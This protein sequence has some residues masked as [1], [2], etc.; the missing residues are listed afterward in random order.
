[1]ASASVGKDFWTEDRLEFILK[2]SDNCRKQWPG[3]AEKKVCPKKLEN[4]TA[5]FLVMSELM[6][7]EERAI[8][9]VFHPGDTPSDFARFKDSGAPLLK[10]RV[11]TCATRVTGNLAGK[12]DLGVIPFEGMPYAPVLIPDWESDEF[13]HPF[14]FITAGVDGLSRETGLDGHN[15]VLSD[16]ISTLDH[17][18]SLTQSGWKVTNEGLN[19][20]A[21]LDAECSKLVRVPE[22]IWFN[23]FQCLLTFGRTGGEV[24]NDEI[25]SG[26]SYQF[27]P[28]LNWKRWSMEKFRQNRKLA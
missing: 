28:F 14:F 12:V 7:I 9:R 11:S 19:F 18:L 8:G 4:A 23:F 24:F 3:D 5:Q 21:A 1:M 27:P 6:R 20:V 2:N 25:F 10:G 13:P 16:T 17:V 26:A 15:E 22:Y